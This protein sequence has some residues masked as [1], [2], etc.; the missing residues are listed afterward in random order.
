MA[1]VLEYDIEVGEFELQ[2]HIYVHFQTNTLRKD[3]DPL[4]PASYVLK[5]SLLF[6][7]KDDICIS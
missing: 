3:M 4:N 6:F 2:S 1:N 5:G 7:G